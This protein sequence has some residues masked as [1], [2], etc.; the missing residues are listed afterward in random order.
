VNQ[1]FAT[2][3]CN[4]DAGGLELSKMKK[5]KIKI[6]NKQIQKRYKLT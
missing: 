2:L 3:E 5:K 1:T 6:K 4:Q